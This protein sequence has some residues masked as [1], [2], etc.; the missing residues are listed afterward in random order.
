MSTTPMPRSRLVFLS[1]FHSTK[2]DQNMTPENWIVCFLFQ[3]WA[4]M[5]WLAYSYQYFRVN[6]E[7]VRYVSAH[8]LTQALTCCHVPNCDGF[9]PGRVLVSEMCGLWSS[10]SRLPRIPI[11]I[12]STECKSSR[13]HHTFCSWCLRINSSCICL[14][15][16]GACGQ[17]LGG[18]LSVSQVTTGRATICKQLLCLS[19]F[20]AF[21]SVSYS[22]QRY[23]QSMFDFFFNM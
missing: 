9:K 22:S 14:A 5:R 2:L 3:T 12:I 15:W 7:K 19:L 13:P 6:F 20:V 10:K 8:L 18:R 21:R 4:S 16:S 11:Q 23:H 1:V 17:S